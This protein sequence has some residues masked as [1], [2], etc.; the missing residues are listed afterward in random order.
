MFATR[1]ICRP[2]ERKGLTLK[3]NLTAVTF[4]KSR[5]QRN[6][7]F[8]NSPYTCSI[9]LRKR[10]LS[11]R[12]RDKVYCSGLTNAAQ[13]LFFAALHYTGR[14]SWIFI[15]TSHDQLYKLQRAVACVLVQRRSL[16]HNKWSPKSS[17]KDSHFA[18]SAV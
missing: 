18:D 7:V 14:P 13:P 9:I 5:S 16:A 17:G 1:I 8:A 11:V 10:N 3:F 4:V 15:P 6:G 2:S 12:Q